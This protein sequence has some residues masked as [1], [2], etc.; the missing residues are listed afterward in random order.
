MRDRGRE[1]KS[2]WVRFGITAG[3]PAV[4]R[5]S[6]LQNLRKRTLSKNVNPVCM[7]RALEI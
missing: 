6:Y 3:G 5:Q 7:L 1:R 2:A 4:L